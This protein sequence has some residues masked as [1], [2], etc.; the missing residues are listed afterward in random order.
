MNKNIII[1][2]LI[3]ALVV[4]GG[5]TY[6]TLTNT[7]PKKAEAQCEDIINTQVIPKA[8]TDCQTA[9][10]TAVQAVQQYQQILTQLKQVPACAALFPAQ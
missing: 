4:L 1:V 7:V 10:A 5:W 9:M 8:Q 6:Y 2:V 3:V